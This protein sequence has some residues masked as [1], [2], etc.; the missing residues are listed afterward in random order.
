MLSF[1]YSAEEKKRIVEMKNLTRI[2]FFLDE[3]RIER[4]KRSSNSNINIKSRLDIA[5]ER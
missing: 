4:N 3:T 2:S 1:L 5:V